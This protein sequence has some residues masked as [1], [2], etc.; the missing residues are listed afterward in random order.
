[1]RWI[2]S[3]EEVRADTFVLSQEGR[4]RTGLAALTDHLTLTTNNSH[5]YLR[6]SGQGIEE[7]GVSMCSRDGI[8]TLCSGFVDPLIRRCT[9]FPSRGRVANVMSELMANLKAPLI[10]F[11]GKTAKY[12]ILRKDTVATEDTMG[13]ITIA[14]NTCTDSERIRINAVSTNGQGDGE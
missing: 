10:N 2:G 9:Q 13:I 5:P 12:L 11:Q 8:K 14:N 3:T 1:M 7:L 4:S 6:A